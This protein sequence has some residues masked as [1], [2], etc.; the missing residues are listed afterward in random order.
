MAGTIVSYTKQRHMME[1][2]LLPIEEENSPSNRSLS[3]E[4]FYEV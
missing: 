2:L 3:N 4:V 1:K